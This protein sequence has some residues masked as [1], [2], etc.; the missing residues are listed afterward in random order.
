MLAVRGAMD[1]LQRSASFS[2]Q[3][4]SLMRQPSAEDLDAAHQL[5]SSA[6]GERHGS[7]Q[8]LAH[9]NHFRPVS[10]G[11]DMTDAPRATS[12]LSEQ[13]EEPSGLGQMCR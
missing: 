8:H 1:A 12:E 2:S 10:P 6:R 11:P 9:D 4:D 13:T 5:V 7:Q 3:R